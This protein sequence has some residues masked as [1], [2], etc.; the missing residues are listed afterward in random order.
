MPASLGNVNF[1]SQF[2]NSLHDSHPAD[3]YGKIAD[4]ILG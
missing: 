4:P 1:L 2:V 3:R